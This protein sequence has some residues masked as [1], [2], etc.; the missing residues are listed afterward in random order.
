MLLQ[1]LAEMVASLFT[2]KSLSHLA[3]LMAAAVDAEETLSL[4][5]IA[6]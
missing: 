1:A 5:L 3:A 4:L 6:E 2:V